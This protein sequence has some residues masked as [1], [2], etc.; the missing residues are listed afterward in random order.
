LNEARINVP[1]AADEMGAL[2]AMARTD[3]RH[4]REEL[5][6][7]FV[8]EARRRGLLPILEDAEQAEATADTKR[9]PAGKEQR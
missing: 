1:L 5:R 7:V 2:L 6:W 9:Q 3:C 4:P 8:Q